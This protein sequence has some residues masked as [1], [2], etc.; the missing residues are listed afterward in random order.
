MSEATRTAETKK[1][2]HRQ[3][4][5]NLR[6]TVKD[7]EEKVALLLQIDARNNKVAEL[8]SKLKKL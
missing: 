8:Q 6:E 5:A 2:L 7:L 1:E 3:E 4:I